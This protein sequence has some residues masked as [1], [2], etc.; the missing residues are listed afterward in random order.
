MLPC[1]IEAR[2][3]Y[4]KRDPTQCFIIQRLLD[5]STTKGEVDN[6]NVRFSGKWD[7]RKTFF[8]FNWLK[9]INNIPN[10]TVQ[11][12]SFRVKMT[13]LSSE[14]WISRKC[15]RWEEIIWTVFLNS[16]DRKLLISFLFLNLFWLLNESRV[17]C[18]LA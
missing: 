13:P 10:K 6:V 17:N 1:L 7:C 2:Q 16:I 4:S 11:L 18:K 5:E 3:T 15:K 9:R 12:M 8:F 14:K